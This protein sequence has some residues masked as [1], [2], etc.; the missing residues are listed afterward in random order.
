MTTSQK[1]KCQEVNALNHKNELLRERR[2][3]N[4]CALSTNTTLLMYVKVVDSSESQPEKGS[5][6]LLS[7]TLYMGLHLVAH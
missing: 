3:R 7:T 1:D 4:A 2:M 6:Q 5:L